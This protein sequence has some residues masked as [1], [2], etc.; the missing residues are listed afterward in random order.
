MSKQLSILLTGAF[1]FLFSSACTMF[2]LFDGSER[3]AQKSLQATAT[4]EMALTATYGSEVSNVIENFEL[5]WYSF[6]AH[7]DPTIQSEL[8]TGAYL[9]YWGYARKGEAIYD[10]PSWSIITF[11]DVN[12]IRVLEYSSKRFKAVASVSRVFNDIT[13]EGKV[14]QS[15]RPGG[16]CGIYVFT[17]EDDVWKLVG[18]FLTEGPPQDVERDWRNA[19]DWLK[20][21]IGDLPEGDLCEW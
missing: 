4:A 10:E 7:V 8:A 12:Y 20:D 18:F 19:P 11:A 16:H 6:E 9:D 5:Q 1:L 2:G 15:L 14:I 17:Y 3:A 21:P 13:P